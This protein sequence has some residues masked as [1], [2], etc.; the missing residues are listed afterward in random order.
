MLSRLASRLTYANVM[1]TL[2]LFIALGGGA[3]AAVKLPRNSVGSVQI[4]NG[5]VTP[6]KVAGS[7]RAVFRGQTG[8]QGP[9]GATGPQGPQGNAGPPGRDG[10]TKVVERQTAK[11]TSTGSNDSAVVQCQSGEVATGGGWDFDSGNVANFLTFG[12]GPV[13]AD[14]TDAGPGQT[15]TGWHVS[16]YNNSGSTDGWHV[17]VICASP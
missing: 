11:S 7:T 1:A 9:K 14:G 8:P 12:D 3:Y 17:Y 13:K 16:V 10:S 6:Q 5:A 2:A 15:P 4:K